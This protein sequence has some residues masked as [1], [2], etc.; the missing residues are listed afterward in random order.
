MANQKTLFIAQGAMSFQARGTRKTQTVVVRPGL[1]D[2]GSKVRWRG[3]R[4]LRFLIQQG[5]NAIR[6]GFDQFDNV[7]IVGESNFRHIEAFALIQFLF[8]LQDVVVEELLELLI[9]VVD[10]ELLERVHCEVLETGNVEHADV[11]VGG[12]EGDALVDQTDDSVKEA[13]VDG[14]GQSIPSVACLINFQRNPVNKN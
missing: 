5:E 3:L 1:V 14:L 10:A 13:T 9:A 8:V 7:L 12:L 2:L 6:L 11:E 4:Q